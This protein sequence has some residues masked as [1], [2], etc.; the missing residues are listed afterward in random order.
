CRAGS[1]TA[2]SF[3]DDP[4][5]LEEYAWFFDNS[6]E[7]YHKVGTKKPN[8]WGLFDMH[9]NVA[10][11]TLDQHTTDFY[12]QCQKEGVVSNPLA[13]PKTEYPIAVRG[14]SWND[15]PEVLRSAARVGS[16]AAWKRQD[17]QIPKSIWYFTDAT[18]VGF[19]IVR[20]LNEPSAEE[21]KA[22]WDKAE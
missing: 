17:P 3:G 13:N 9:G 16:E 18:H 11:W 2:Y 1:T 6:G 10:E 22:K 15:D 5:D 12:A 21:R 7:K 19:R 20:P 4:A 14:G 8:A